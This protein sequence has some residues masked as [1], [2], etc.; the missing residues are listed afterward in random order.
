[1]IFIIIICK[2]KNDTTGNSLFRGQDL[3]NINFSTS[4]I[5]KTASYPC[6]MRQN[7]EGNNSIPESTA[8]LLIQL[9]KGIID[10]T[11]QI[12]NFL[13]EFEKSAALKQRYL[14]CKT[15]N[16]K[17][18]LLQEAGFVFRSVQIHQI[19]DSLLDKPLSDDHLEQVSGGMI[20]LDTGEVY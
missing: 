8:K 1:M 5:P 18:L 17:A 12:D 4:H 11:D 13:N 6:I 7:N 19:D 14:Q 16:E 20:E 3:K 2:V 15:E 9:H 10:M